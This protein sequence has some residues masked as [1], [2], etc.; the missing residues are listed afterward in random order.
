MPNFEFQMSEALVSSGNDNSSETNMLEIAE[1][2]SD[3]L[4]SQIPDFNDLSSD[5][6]YFDEL[7]II[8]DDY[9][10]TMEMPNS[11]QHA[12]TSSET[13]NNTGLLD[14]SVFHN[15][16]VTININK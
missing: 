13:N 16:T 14:N 15:C 3:D 12:R 8:S 5:W 2:I 10:A 11:L 1:E 7:G 9:L 6:N 4:L